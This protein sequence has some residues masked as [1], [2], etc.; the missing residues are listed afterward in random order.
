MP[1][2]TQYANF[3]AAS[4]GILMPVMIRV[5]PNALRMS[6]INRPL[7]PNALRTLLQC[8]GD[9]GHVAS[10]LRTTYPTVIKVT[11]NN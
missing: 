6:V 8:A 11:N 4:K 9:D 2:A 1:E 5:H 10:E 3:F 7:E